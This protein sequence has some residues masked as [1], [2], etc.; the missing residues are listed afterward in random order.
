M[1][2]TFAQEGYNQPEYE[3]AIMVYL[4]HEHKAVTLPDVVVG[5]GLKMEWVEYTLR[6]MLG[7]FPAF[8]EINDKQELTYSFDLTPKSLPVGKYFM[9]AIGWVFWAIWQV[10]TIAFKVWIVVMLCTYAVSYMLILTLTIAVI[11]RSGDIFEAVFQGIFYGVGE[12]W[13]MLTGKSGK[14]EKSEKSETAS[15]IED[16]HTLNCIFSYVFGAT[17]PKKDKLATEKLILQYIRIHAGKLVPVDIVRLTGWSLRDAQT[18][19]AYLLAHYQGEVSV[20]EEGKIVYDFPDLV[21]AGGEQNALP[22]PIWK[23]PFVKP[24]MNDTDKDTHSAITWTNWFNIGMSIATPIIAL[25]MFPELEGEVPEWIIVW[26]TMIPFTFSFIFFLVP[27]C[28]YF[29]V[30][31]QQVKAQRAY[32]RLL[33]LGEIFDRLPAKITPDMPIISKNVA[34][35]EEAQSMRLVAELPAKEREAIL[36]KLCVDMNA[37]PIATD[38]G[39]EYDF[40]ELL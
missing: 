10:F 6:Q 21:K 19:A 2:N 31:R 38:K 40:K 8:L 33:V 32:H 17:P 3:D 29:F 22:A 5:T 15:S 39:V 27:A 14:S 20:T 23:S 13:N 18:Q 30:Y 11:T 24:L 28:R 12:L 1:K 37:E 36:K 16:K 4:K 7:K 26:F 34:T 9:E 35:N 25:C